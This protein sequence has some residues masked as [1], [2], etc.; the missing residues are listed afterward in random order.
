MHGPSPA[1]HSLARRAS[2]AGARRPFFEQKLSFLCHPARGTPIMDL[3][4]C[5]DVAQGPAR[6]TEI[7]QCL[8]RLGYTG[9]ALE[10]A[11]TLPLRP[12][13]EC[14]RGAAFLAPA[15]AA[16]AHAAG[17]AGA[18]PVH[19]LVAAATVVLARGRPGSLLSK[20]AA[21]RLAARVGSLPSAGGSGGGGAPAAAGRKRPRADEGG[22]SSSSSSSSSAAPPPPPAAPFHEYRRITLLLDPASSGGGGGG[23]GFTSTRPLSTDLKEGAAVLATYDLVAAQPSDAGG[24][25]AIAAAGGGGAIDIVT[26]DMSSGR[27]PFPLSRRDL[28]AALAAGQVLE[29]RYA[30]AIRDAALRRAFFTH[31]ATLLRLTRGAGLL[32][33][34]GA[35]QALELRSP[36]AV[37]AIAS[38]AGLSLQQALTALT[39]APAAALAHAAKRRQGLL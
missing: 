19:D 36:R 39:A 25:A 11:T 9:A 26:L 13:D 32:L 15:A 27:L 35:R 22:G 4:V 31:A 29:L 12:K 38:L 2:R 8:S 34:S 20:R 14:R 6:I 18:P 16:A 5:C 37:A 28:A 3:C 23:G 1:P 24:L 17:G 10:H 30:P 33:T 7:Y 21:R